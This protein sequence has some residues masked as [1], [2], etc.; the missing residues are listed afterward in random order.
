MS[1][2]SNKPGQAAVE[3]TGPTIKEAAPAPEQQPDPHAGKGGHYE[4]VGGVRRLVERT[5]GAS[6]EAVSV[7]EDPEHA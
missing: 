2:V 7:K 4:L 1:K 5:G 3:I 6:A